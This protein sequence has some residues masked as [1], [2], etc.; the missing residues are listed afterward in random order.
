M[1]S[2]KIIHIIQAFN[3]LLD[4]K[5]SLYAIP[6]EFDKIS[7]IMRKENLKIEIN[8]S[9][10]FYQIEELN[11]VHQRMK[12]ANTIEEAAEWYLKEKELLAENAGSETTDLKQEPGLFEYKEGRIIGFLS[13]RRENERLIWNLTEGYML[14]ERNSS[15]K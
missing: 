3:K 12:E 11:R 8:E 13:K 2:K 6:F 1:D 4:D 9:R 14:K 5:L 10:T 7:D 15:N